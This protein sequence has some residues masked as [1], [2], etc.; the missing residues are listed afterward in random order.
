MEY[1]GTS[2][3]SITDI[4]NMGPGLSMI[5]L[6]QPSVNSVVPERCQQSWKPK[7]FV[8]FELY[9]VARYGKSLI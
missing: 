8:M 6:I 5:V 9:S 2:I 1:M 4:A 3:M 7:L